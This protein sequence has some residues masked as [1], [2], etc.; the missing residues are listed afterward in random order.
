MKIKLARRET[1]NLQEVSVKIFY[2]GTRTQNIDG[3][4]LYV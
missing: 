4:A 1:R 2:I 3:L